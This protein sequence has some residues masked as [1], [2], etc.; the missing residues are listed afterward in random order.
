M[1]HQAE[2]LDDATLTEAQLVE[3]IDDLV[4][5]PGSLRSVYQPIV[6]LRSGECLGY[7]ALTRVAQWPAHSP[8]PWFTAAS[9]SGLAA[10]FEEAA[11]RG[12]LRGRT[13]MPAGRFL[14][15]NLSAAGLQYDEVVRLLLDQPDL[16]GLV[17]EITD[18]PA[19]LADPQGLG[20]L[21]E[22]RSRGLMA[23]ADLEDAGAR[24]LTRISALRPDLVKL[25]RLLVHGVHGDPVRQR[26]LRSVAGFVSE[27]GAVCLGEGLEQREDALALQDLGIRLGQGWLFG[28]ARPGFLP[29]TDESAGWLAAG[30]TELVDRSRLARLVRAVPAVPSGAPAEPGGWRAELAPDGRLLVLV[31][32]QGDRVA[33]SELVRLRASADVGTAARRLVKAGDRGGTRCAAVVNDLGAFVGLA[34]IDRVLSEAVLSGWPDAAGAARS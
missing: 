14:T 30:W 32:P 18:V 33:G 13:A 17:I 16:H 3:Q 15:V 5:R 23:A 26:V 25:E 8:Q 1:L 28:R 7:E 29:P 31:T 10:R 21:A 34:D 22:L 19:L 9:R 20:M 12:A 2:L 4:R 11:L 24:E 6:D 27:L